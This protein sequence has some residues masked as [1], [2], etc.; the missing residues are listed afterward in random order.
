MMFTI[1][2]SQLQNNMHFILESWRLGLFYLNLRFQFQLNRLVVNSLT[3]AGSAV[4][5]KI[6][7]LHV[8]GKNRQHAK[9][10]LLFKYFYLPRSSCRLSNIF[11]RSVDKFWKHPSL[12][13]WL[14]CFLL[15]LSPLVV[16]LAGSCPI[17]LKH[18]IT[19]CR[20]IFGREGDLNLVWQ[21][22]IAKITPEQY[23][24][25]I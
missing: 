6:N 20:R 5:F 3:L 18:F 24:Q 7:K 9:L 14:N 8:R 22:A 17:V 16:G 15:R 19:P 10:I 25:W 4:S 11:A 1:I 12:P 2:G 21:K 23:W 13:T